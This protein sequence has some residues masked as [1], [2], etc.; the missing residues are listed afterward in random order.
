VKFDYNSRSNGYGIKK[1][2]LE[3]YKKNSFKREILLYLV[4]LQ[5]AGR[6]P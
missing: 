3:D 5:P 4:L 2:K 6:H 1:G